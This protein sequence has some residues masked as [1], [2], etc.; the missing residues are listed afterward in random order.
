MAAIIARHPRGP[1]REH[2]YCIL[3]LTPSVKIA[4]AQGR[5]LFDSCTPQQA[6][7]DMILGFYDQR[8]DIYALECKLKD[9]EAELE[10]AMNALR[11]NA[12]SR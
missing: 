1:Q 10:R 9:A 8:E 5:K 6:A 2:R 11:R 3:P 4:L 12:G 7:T